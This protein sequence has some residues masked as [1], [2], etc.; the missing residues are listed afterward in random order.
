MKNSSRQRRPCPL[1]ET[2]AAALL[3][4]LLAG[5]GATMCLSPEDTWRR[6]I[7]IVKSDGVETLSLSGLCSHSAWGV[8]RLVLREEGDGL[9]LTI[10]LKPRGNGDFKYDVVIGDKINR[11][12]WNGV[13]IWERGRG[14]IPVK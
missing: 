7:R 13:L 3:L 6:D 8:D 1:M 5:C 11:A 2:G 12:Y 14:I 9:F 10:L 4:L